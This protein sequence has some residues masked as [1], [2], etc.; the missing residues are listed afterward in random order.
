MTLETSASIHLLFIGVVREI[1][2]GL[3]GNVEK[4][5]RSASFDLETGLPEQQGGAERLFCATA[6]PVLPLLLTSVWQ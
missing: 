6:C 3:K 1:I 5:K 2:V 4:V